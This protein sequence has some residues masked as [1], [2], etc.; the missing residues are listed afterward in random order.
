M[1]D[2]ANYL[3][4]PLFYAEKCQVQNI[5]LKSSALFLEHCDF[6]FSK[7]TGINAVKNELS[8]NPYFSGLRVRFPL[9]LK[10]KAWMNDNG[11]VYFSVGLIRTTKSARLLAVVWHE[12]AHVYLGRQPF[13]TELKTL[14]REFKKKFTVN[15]AYLL[16]PI[17]ISAMALSITV[18]KQISSNFDC[19][20]YLNDV[21]K[22]ESGKLSV[23]LE[24][25]SRLPRQE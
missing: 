7:I 23:L 1:S 9:T 20:A 13:Y 19:G 2:L 22:E 18:L 8:A 4:N 21:I 11:T 12:F 17:E 25:I 24:E 10:R 15:T 16:S 3:N 5:G 14:N 6:F